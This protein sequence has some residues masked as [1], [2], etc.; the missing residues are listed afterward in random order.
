MSNQ[1]QSQNSGP[2]W[3]RISSVIGVAAGIIILIVLIWWTGFSKF[4]KAIAKGGPALLLLALFYPFELCSRAY[5][6]KF[7]FPGKN[8]PRDS[9]FIRGFWFAQSINRLLPTATIGGIFVRGSFLNNRNVDNTTTISSLI[10]DK[11]AHAVS[12]IVILI[13]GM[14][15]M[16]TQSVNEKILILIPSICLILAVGTYFF[17]RLQRSSGVSKVLEKWSGKDGGFLSSAREKA[18]EIE[19]HLD[20]IYRHPRNFIISVVIRVAGDIAMASEIWFAA[21]LMN[22][23]INIIDAVTLRLITFGVRSAAFVIWG[24]LGIQESVYALLSAFIGLSPS[25]LI[26]ISLATRVQEII[27]AIPGVGFWL[28]EEGY[29]AVRVKRSES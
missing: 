12:T 28:A 22:T 17:I 19:Q 8:L 11:T 6:W 16:L 4:S 3:S 23:P 5:G 29:H 20:G 7:V 24:G 13:L 15:L 26:A 21:W 18:D 25:E 2:S 27:T 9:L 1:Q 10:A 14:L